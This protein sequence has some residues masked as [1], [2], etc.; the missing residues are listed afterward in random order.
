MNTQA[1]AWMERGRSFPSTPVF[2][3]LWLPAGFV[4]G[5]L[6]LLGPVRWWAKACRFLELSPRMENG[7]V[8]LMIGILFMISGYT[9]RIITNV[10]E[11][12]RRGP[13]IVTITAVLAICSGAMA[14]WM[15]P[16]LMSGSMATEQ[17]SARITFGP[18]PDERRMIQLK[19]DGYTIV[20]LLHPAV[21]PFEPKLLSDE[22]RMARQTGIP[23]IH[24]PMLPW[25]SGNTEALATIKQ[26]A[27]DQTRHFYIHC[28][29][30][31]DRVRIVQRAL[32]QAGVLLSAE[33]KARHHRS[34]RDKARFERGRVY[35]LAS[36]VHVTGYPTDDEFM[37]YVLA[38]EIRHVVALLDSHDPEQRALIDH[39]RALLQQHD[40]LFTLVQSDKGR[41]HARR[42]GDAARTVA[43]MPRP[44][45]VHAFLS[46]SSGQSPWA[47]GFIQTF[48]SQRASLSPTLFRVPL[49]RGRADVVVTHVAIGPPPAQAD[50]RVLAR[51]GVV[52]C[53]HVG[54]ERVSGDAKR[55]A[56]A[57]L[58]WR[59]IK[60]DR[61]VSAVQSG[62]P[63]YVYGSDA[64]NARAA[65]EQAYRKPVPLMTQ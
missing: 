47:D 38:G 58:R 45:L 13:R 10:L 28:Y 3:F 17:H 60:R 18:Y 29:L 6:T 53:I 16:A 57:G 21:V 63:Y 37:W 11:S 23:L 7:G 25:I 5:T 42:V 24:V 46:P 52:E 19:R 31:H 43:R 55:A 12:S 49:K 64:T 22:K 30:G 39:E 33:N 8:F 4:L 44:V 20:S 2:L 61:L 26:L 9:A 65:L 15:H 59:S 62:G 36:D 54:S 32:E 41:Y 14:A 40:V 1:L 35:H 48:S 51:R 34:I 56:H 27:S 50:L